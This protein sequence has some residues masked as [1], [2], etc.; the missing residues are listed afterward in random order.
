MSDVA[1]YNGSHL[2]WESIPPDDGHTYLNSYLMICGEAGQPTDVSTYGDHIT[3]RYL[4]TQ[5][6]GIYDSVLVDPMLNPKYKIKL[7]KPIG[8]I[9]DTITPKGGYVVPVGTTCWDI[10]QGLVSGEKQGEDGYQEKKS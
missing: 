6:W 7:S 1:H 10:K 2:S 9:G 4:I 8:N 3:K 5:H